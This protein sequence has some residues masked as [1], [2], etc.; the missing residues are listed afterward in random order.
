MKALQITAAGEINELEDITLESLQQ[1]VGGLIQAIG[2]DG[3]TLWCNDEGK[4]E[5]LPHN[6]YAQ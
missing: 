6:P 4:M 5:G 2:L 1:G 3:L